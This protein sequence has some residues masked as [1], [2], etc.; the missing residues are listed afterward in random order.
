MKFFLRLSSFR[1]FN[2]WGRS[3]TVIKLLLKLRILSFWRPLKFSIFRILLSFRSSTSKLGKTSRFS[4]VSM[5][6]LLKIRTRR[7]WKDAIFVISDSLL[8][9][10]S[11]KVKFGRLTMFSILVISFYDRFSYLSF[12]SPSR[13][14][15]CLRPRLS[16]ASFSELAIRSDGLR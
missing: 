12:S 3:S 7:C 8:E 14:G 15:T 11:R 10:R 6:F 9:D 16:R 4:I 13:S 5:E 1:F 2:A